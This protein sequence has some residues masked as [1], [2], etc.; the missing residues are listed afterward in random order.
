VS[1]TTGLLVGPRSLDWQKIGLTCA[2]VAEAAAL[3]L[4][5]ASLPRPG[6]SA[7]PGAPI[8][9]ILQSISGDET[10]GWTFL[11]KTY[12]VTAWERQGPVLWGVVAIG[13]DNQANGG[14]SRPYPIPAGT[15]LYVFPYSGWVPPPYGP[16]VAEYNLSQGSWVS[17]ATA[18]VEDG[19]WVVLH[20]MIPP[21]QWSAFSGPS[22]I[23]S[24]PNGAQTIT[25]YTPLAH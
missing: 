11:I 16:G 20:G 14:P 6:P 5:F 2:V 23:F 22:L 18:Q 19:Q 1:S 4:V 8:V 15:S 3:V 13:L 25:F 7:P 24:Y 21:G 9:F 10:S 12:V 17:G